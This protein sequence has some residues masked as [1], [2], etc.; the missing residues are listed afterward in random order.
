M[1]TMAIIGGGN[2]LHLTD[3]SGTLQKIE[4]LVSVNTPQ[5]T[6]ESVDAT[7]QDSGSVMEFIPGIADPGELN[8]ELDYLP[9]SAT[10][11]LL[12]EHI[13]SGETRAFKSF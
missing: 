8:A 11:E 3:N 5:L 12:R 1:T 9:D 7:N 10:D 4:G 6:V 2:E 13:A